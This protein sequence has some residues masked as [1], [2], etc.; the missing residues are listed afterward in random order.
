[1]ISRAV[2]LATVLL[3]AATLAACVNPAR[4]PASVVGTACKVAGATGSAVGKACAVA[5]ASGKAL[6][7]GKK[8]LT[9]HVGSAVKTILGGGGSASTASTALGLAA[10]VTWVV[11]GAQFA[12]SETTKV[13]GETTKP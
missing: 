13:L 6:S 8:L 1:M 2:V 4:A 9:G 11:G 10:M 7:A 5:S 3:A 12:I